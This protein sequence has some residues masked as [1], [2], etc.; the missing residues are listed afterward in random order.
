MK[1]TIRSLSFRLTIAFMVVSVLGTV[2][3]ALLVNWQTRRQFGNL[4]QELY[5]NDLL[6]LGEQLAVYYEE[7]GRWAG[8]EAVIFAEQSSESPQAWHSRKLP[9]TLVDS[10][11]RVVFGDRRYQPGQ[12]LPAHVVQDGLSIEVAG[13]PVGWLVLDSFGSSRYFSGSPEANFLNNLTQTTRLIALGV[14][15]LA[16]SLGIVL[17]RTISRPLSELKA[18]TQRVAQGELGHQVGVRSPDEIGQLAASFNQMSV[19]LARANALRRQMTADI[20]HDL[21]TPLSVLQGYTEAL[22]DGKLPGSSDIFQVMHRQVKHL[23][24]LVEDLRTLSLADAG[25]LSLHP[26]PVAPRDLLEHTALIYA[27]QAEKQQVTLTLEIPENLPHISVDLDRL[28]QV[29][30]NLISNALRHTPTGG[31]I[32]LAAKIGRQELILQVQD[33]GAGIAAKDLPHVFD[34][35]Y[36]ADQSRA[37]NGESGLGL[38]IARSIVE[39]HNGRIT[40]SSPPGQGT[41]FTITLPTA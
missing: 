1:I 32:R 13:S 30:G 11:Q 35:F 27:S 40:A 41:T 5:Q 4:V 23:N 21:R 36:R 19:D 22:D 6:I 7:N 24:R 33:T 2:L 34:R 8:V 26:Q 39:A 28:V 16:L 9:V 10:Q 12:Q 29:L 38:A 14:A 15:V 31:H 17:A 37:Q 3:V 25:Q 20:A 18:A